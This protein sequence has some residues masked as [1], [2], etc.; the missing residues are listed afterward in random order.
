M[1]CLFA[2]VGIS[3]LLLF[4][5]ISGAQ[6]PELDEAFKQYST[7]SSEGK[8]G[9]EVPFAERFLALAK[10]EFGETHSVYASGL[11]VLG[12]LYYNQGRYA[13]AEPSLQA[14]A[15]DL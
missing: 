5:G 3:V 2:G 6:S 8:Y 14:L 1:R 15:S 11:T 13:D 10:T 7:L 9:E 4:S 12:L